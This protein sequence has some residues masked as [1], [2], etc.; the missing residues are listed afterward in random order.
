MMK[1]KFNRP[2]RKHMTELVTEESSLKKTNQVGK[3]VAGLTKRI[4]KAT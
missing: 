3:P 2:K 1:A 4:R